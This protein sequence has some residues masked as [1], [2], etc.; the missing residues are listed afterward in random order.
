MKKYFVFLLLLTTSFTKAKAQVNYQTGS[1]SFSLPMFNWKDNKSRLS[2]VVALNYSSGNGL[3]VNELAS[4]I[5]QGWSLMAGGV[6]TR[7]QVGEPDDQKPR[8]GAIDDQTKYPPGILYNTVPLTQGCPIGLMKYPVFEG[9]NK[10]YRPNNEVAAD[11]EKDYFSFQF[12]GRS[13]MFVVNGDN[14]GTCIG[15]NK[16]KVWF[17]RDESASNPNRTTINAFYI[18]DENGLVYTYNKLDRTRVMK[19]GYMDVNGKA[20]QSLPNFKGG[21]VFYQGT[22]DKQGTAQYIVSAWLLTE[23]KDAL[24]GRVVRFGYVDRDI[25]ALGDVQLMYFKEKDYSIV[26]QKRSVT[27]SP[28]ISSITYPDGHSVQFSYDKPRLD[29]KGDNV[30]TSVSVKYKER[31]VSKFTL[32][33]D[34]FILNRYGTPVTE[35]QKKVARLCLLSVK[36]SGVDLKAEE[37]PYLFDYYIGS[38]APDDFVP[39]PFFYAKD[40]WGYYNGDNSKSSANVSLPMNKLSTDLNNGQVKGLCFLRDNN[41]SPIY[42]AKA[43]YA[44]NGLLKEVIYPAGGTLSYEYE[45][46]MGTLDGQERPVGGVHVSKIRTTDGGFS[47]GDDKPL[48]TKY[49]FVLE[50]GA[51]SSLWGL[52]KPINQT[53]NSA[54]YKPEPKKIKWFPPG[55]KFQYQYPGLLSEEDRM[56][57][58]NGQYLMQSLNTVLSMVGIAMQVKDI[59]MLFTA[60]GV[61]WTA[62]A[63]VTISIVMDA[64]TCFNSGE[65]NI[66]TTIFYNADLNSANPLPRQFKRVEITPQN[67]EVGKTVSTFTSEDQYPLWVLPEKNVNYSMAQRYASWAY[68]LPLSTV[69]YDKTGNK[70]KETSYTYECINPYQDPVNINNLAKIGTASKISGNELF[71]FNNKLGGPN[72]QPGGYDTENVNEDLSSVKA[73]GECLFKVPLNKPSLKCYVTRTKSQRSVDWSNPDFFSGASN[74]T[75]ANYNKDNSIMNVEPY[76]LFTGHLNLTTINEREYK[77]DGRTLQT[78]TRYGYDMNNYQINTVLTDRSDG[79]RIKKQFVYSDT[80]AGSLFDGMRQ[81]NMLSVP[82]MEISTVEGKPANNG[83]LGRSTNSFVKLANGDIKPSSTSIVKYAIPGNGSSSVT[84]NQM[85]QYDAAGNMVCTKAE[86][87]SVSYIYDYD[88]KYVAATVVNADASVDKPAFCGFETASMGGWSLTGSPSYN[89]TKSLTGVRSLQLSSSLSAPINATKPYTVSF[90][91]TGSLG[92]SGG[93]Q[94]KSGPTLN[95]FTYYEYLVQ[96][97]STVTVAGSATIDEL[98]LYPKEARMSTV[99]YDPLIGKTSECGADNRIVYYEYDERGRIKYIRDEKKNVLKVYEYQNSVKP[100]RTYRNNALSETFAANNCQGDFIGREIT[101]TIAEG[102][103]SSTVSQADADAKAQTELNTSGQA[104]ANSAGCTAIFYNDIQ[105]RDFQKEDCAAGYKGT[106][107]TYTVPARRYFSLIS[108]EDANNMA[109]EELEANGDAFANDPKNGSCVID[110][111]PQWL[112]QDPSQERCGTGSA[113]GHREIYMKDINPNSPSYN[114][115]QWKDIG[116]DAEGCPV[117]NKI[118]IYTYVMASDFAQ[119]TYSLQEYVSGYNSGQLAGGISSRLEMNILPTPSA[120][121]VLKFS[122]P[123]IPKSVTLNVGSSSTTKSLNGGNSVAF[124]GVNLS[125]SQTLNIFFNQR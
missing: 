109:L 26:A 5:G 95:G 46:N 57:I 50:G 69:A 121:I 68:G 94:T 24:T 18:Q 62:I 107:V 106:M 85:Y 4:N 1:G 35:Y 25:D 70:V 39:P 17:T 76:D 103:Y 21:K 73:L 114:T 99:A 54:F 56:S 88:D 117:S 64:I 28:A 33:S 8:D 118:T 81:Q 14:T 102:K 12:N 82:V 113:A 38:S 111:N 86:G 27:K 119:L 44:K 59:V 23:V 84:D 2:S 75:Q 108:K 55:C 6:I 49:T 124:E 58:S 7:M 3:K 122:G 43:G 87:R 29:V 53:S 105:S 110:P 98:R 90:W 80:Y 83:E 10:I 93:V 115:W 112:A 97:S 45:Q 40:I 48:S 66:N 41:S 116:A 78:S 63:S 34:Y 96:N 91:S 36:Q 123:A 15:D 100:V 42:N 61:P 13:G 16:L 32:N 51:Q 65:K 72:A 120:N 47:N 9:K 31:F 67:G 101:Y 89:T 92:V 30:L 79:A 60:S 77:S 125:T 37:K 71:A 104:A 52:E 19:P 20:E 74:Y 22:F 11:K